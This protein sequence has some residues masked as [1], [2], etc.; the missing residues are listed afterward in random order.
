MEFYPVQGVIG[1]LGY[2]QVGI[3]DSLFI[4]IG[5]IGVRGDIA[6]SIRDLYRAAIGIIFVKGAI[7]LVVRT[8]YDF[9][10]AVIL[11]IRGVA[12]G[13]CPACKP[14]SAVIG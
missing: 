3:G 1:K 4:A 6:F 5:I 13:V 11:K 14:A 12:K 10:V 8:G 7:P 9:A 2:N